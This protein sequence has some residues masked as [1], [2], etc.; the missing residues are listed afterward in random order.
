MEHCYQPFGTK[1]STIDA[2]QGGHDG[3]ALCDGSSSFTA[4]NADLLK[5]LTR[6]LH[7][8]DFDII[9]HAELVDGN[10]L[11]A[12]FQPGPGFDSQGDL[13]GIACSRQDNRA[14]AGA[15][16]QAALVDLN[17]PNLPLIGLHLRWSSGSCQDRGYQS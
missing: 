3:M 12:A 5:L 1:I 17:G 7:G 2:Q 14:F 11:I 13:P 6:K 16:L 10:E 8:L 15:W 4:Q 9:A